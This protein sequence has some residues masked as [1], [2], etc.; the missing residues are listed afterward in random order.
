[1]NGRHSVLGAGNGVSEWRMLGTFDDGRRLE[2][3]GCDF[4][5]VVDGQIVK[6]NSLTKQRPPQVP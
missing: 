3:D 2:F 6:K 4:L 1:V 5:T